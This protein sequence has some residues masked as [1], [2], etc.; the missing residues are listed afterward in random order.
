MIVT[1]LEAVI[2]ERPRQR[3]P[4]RPRTG[5]SRTSRTRGQ[6]H[7]A[8]QQ[9]PE[10][11]THR[12]CLSSRSGISGYFRSYRSMIPASHAD[13]RCLVKIGSEDARGRSGRGSVLR[14][15]GHGRGGRRSR[16]SPA[17]T[18]GSRWRGRPSGGR[19]SCC[20]AST[21][22]PSARPRARLGHHASKHPR[23]T[24]PRVRDNS[25]SFRRTAV[26][27]TPTVTIL[28]R[29]GFMT[30]AGSRPLR[31][32][33][34]LRDCRPMASRPRVVLAEHFRSGQIS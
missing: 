22:S 3:H 2:G 15:T 11:P 1:R 13:R 6:Q 31:L 28:T 7:T 32:I 23:G 18:Q 21:Q 10:P 4:R 19:C 16:N 5:S 8:H 12:R 14:Q 30:A 26:V 9:Q 29:H 34:T 17:G 25:S 33:R 24:S 20:A 27:S